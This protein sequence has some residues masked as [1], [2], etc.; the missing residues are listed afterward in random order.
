MSSFTFTI[1]TAHAK[2]LL[3]AWAFLTPEEEEAVLALEGPE[4][5][6]KVHRLMAQNDRPGAWVL[7]L[8]NNFF[9]PT[10]RKSQL[11]LRLQ[12]IWGKER[13]NESLT[14]WYTKGEEVH[15]GAE[16]ARKR[17]NEMVEANLKSRPEFRSL[18]AKLN[19]T[20]Q[21]AKAA[22]RACKACQKAE[23]E[24][25]Q[26]R[27]SVDDWTFPATGPEALEA[28]RLQRQLNF[29]HCTSR[30]ENKIENLKEAMRDLELEET[31]KVLATAKDK[32]GCWLPEFTEPE[33]EPTEE[34]DW[35]LF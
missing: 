14:W 1:S 34:P 19:R 15:E 32:F 26:L 6:E 33:P 29:C 35:G 3:R 10:D 22:K 7:D 30:F 2:E 4:R 24:L 16:R 5:T 23:E 18:R 9:G 21:Q 17:I 20:R 31:R 27:T 8:A 25:Y 28:A 13:E 11:L 12:T